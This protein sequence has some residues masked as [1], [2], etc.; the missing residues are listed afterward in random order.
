MSS[1]IAPAASAADLGVVRELFR[2]YADGLGFDLTFQDFAA[3]LATLP[4]R[5]APPPGRLLLAWQ[6][7]VPAGC[8]AL[9]QLEGRVCEMKRLYVRPAARGHGIGRALVERVIAEARAAG[10]V[11]MRLDTVPA[12]REAQGLYLALGFREIGA[13]TRNPVPGARFLELEL[14]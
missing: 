1:P 10:Y 6:G 3:E 4:G 12:L 14:A 11:T 13:Y 8:V 9:R 5:Y 7:E 2:E